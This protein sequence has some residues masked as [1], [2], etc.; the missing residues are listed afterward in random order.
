MIKKPQSSSQLIIHALNRSKDLT[1]HELSLECGIGEAAIRYHLRKMKEAGLVQEY[2]TGIQGLRAGRRFYKYR[3]I[4]SDAKVNLER[5]CLSL[6]RRV[7]SNQIIAPRLLS[8]MIAEDLIGDP[9]LSPKKGSAAFLELIKWLNLHHYHARWEAGRKGPV[10]HFENCPFCTIREGN[11]LLCEIDAEIIR[12]LT[13]I[14]WE[15]TGC[16]DWKNNRGEC[17]FTA[18]QAA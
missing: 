3:F 8:R 2:D 18:K 14:E 7:A 13:G 9:I 12:Q 16:L 4:S 5:L 6:L 17:V 1:T 10:V 15:Q 11:N